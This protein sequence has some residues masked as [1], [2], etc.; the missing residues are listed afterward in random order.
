MEHCYLRGQWDVASGS[1]V[2]GLYFAGQDV[3]SE[4]LLSAVHQT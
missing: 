4:S 1:L 2:S 3:Q